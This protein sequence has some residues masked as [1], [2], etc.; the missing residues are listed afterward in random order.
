V[1]LLYEGDAASQAEAKV[2]VRM[3]D[4]AHTFFQQQEGAAGDSG[5][6]GSAGGGSGQQQQQGAGSPC[7]GSG[8]SGAGGEAQGQV[9]ATGASRDDNFHAGLRALLARLRSVVHAQLEQD[10]TA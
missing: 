1:L 4:F 3:V 5:P 2:R 8:S 6:G 7:C 9:A 10:L